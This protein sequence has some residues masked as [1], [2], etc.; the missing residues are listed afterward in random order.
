MHDNFDIFI[1][2]SLLPCLLWLRNDVWCRSYKSAGSEAADGCFWGEVWLVN[3]ERW[4][5]IGAVS[6]RGKVVLVVVSSHQYY[7]VKMYHVSATRCLCTLLQDYMLTA[8][9]CQLS[10]SSAYLSH[11]RTIT[12]KLFHRFVALMTLNNLIL[13][14]IWTSLKCS[15]KNLHS[16]NVS[17]CR[18]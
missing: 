11:F 2:P 16:W 6:G 1:S 4:M 8:Q 3:H 5:H 9:L 7:H 18:R 10:H 15:A 14:H 13:L 12:L 17:N